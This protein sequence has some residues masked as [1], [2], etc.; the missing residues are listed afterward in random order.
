MALELDR[1]TEADGA[2]P[3]I[4]VS[5]HIYCNEYQDQDT[6][7]AAKHDGETDEAAAA[8]PARPSRCRGG[9]RC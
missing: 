3:I 1:D 8:D 4:L 5:Y 6:A 7:D 9:R 2:Y